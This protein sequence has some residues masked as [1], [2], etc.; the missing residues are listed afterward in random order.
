MFVD[1][2]QK[3]ET[4]LETKRHATWSTPNTLYRSSPTHLDFECI[5][6]HFLCSSDE[7]TICIPGS[8]AQNMSKGRV[9]VS[10]TWGPCLCIQPSNKHIKGGSLFGGEFER[11]T[12]LPHFLIVKAKV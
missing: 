12:G 8:K 1:L 3:I 4:S 5:K 10:E 11:T 2:L 6:S 9:A 7:P